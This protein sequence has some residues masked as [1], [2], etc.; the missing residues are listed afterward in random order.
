MAKLSV[1]RLFEA[2]PVLESFAKAKI[3]GMEGFVSYL[4]D[5]SENTIRALRGRLTMPDNFLYE[6]KIVSVKSGI[7]ESIM[8]RETIP[9]RVVLIGKSTPFTSPVQS[10]QWQMNIE[11]GLDIVVTFTNPP[12]SGNLSVLLSIQY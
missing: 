12:A 4:S 1:S 9:A 6:E 2:A 10:F 7:A 8:L 5:F 3:E 11:G